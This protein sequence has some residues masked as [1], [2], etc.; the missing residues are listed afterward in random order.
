MGTSVQFECTRCGAC[1]SQKDIIITLTGKDI[2]R[3]SLFLGFSAD[4][5]LRPLDFY[6]VPSGEEI[7][8]GLKEI[9]S[10]N[11]ERGRAFVALTRMDSNECV[12]L[13]NN[14]CMI[15]SIRPS[16]CVAFPFVF[17]EDDGELEWGLSAKK[18][19]CPG[20]GAGPEIEPSE[21][22]AIAEAVLEDLRVFR[23]FVKEWNA[24]A[25]DATARAFVEA[26]LSD[27]RFAV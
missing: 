19:I 26:V 5:I 18:E 7:P 22:E 12:F 11:T 10:I 6:L 21:L 1:C 14:L 13:K 23:E 20:L 25:E 16:V 17:R 9:P 27:P 8:K 2:K 15:H 24:K 3:M 4:E